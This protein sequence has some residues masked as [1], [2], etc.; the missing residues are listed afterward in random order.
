MRRALFL[1]AL[2]AVPG[3][4]AGQEDD[5]HRWT[6]DDTVLQ[7][8][9]TALIVVDW[10]Q[11]RSF[12]DKVLPDGR[13]YHELNPVLGPSPSVGRLNACV[14]FATIAHAAVSLALPRPYRTW[15]QAAGI[16]LQATNVGRN[17]II[18]GGFH[19][20]FQF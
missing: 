16:T 5:P 4:A 15:W 10:G 2:L 9:M 7:L 20:K 18:H 14:G 19:L 1:A 13:R 11:T 6:T 17:A 12:L 3:A 8:T